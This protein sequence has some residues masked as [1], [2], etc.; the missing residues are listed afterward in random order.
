LD[1]VSGYLAPRSMSGA[2]DTAEHEYSSTASK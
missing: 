2:R 1:T